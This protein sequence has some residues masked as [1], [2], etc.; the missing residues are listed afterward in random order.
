MKSKLTTENHA[1]K[2]RRKAE[3]KTA[4]QAAET[5]SVYCGLNDKKL[6]HELQVHKIELELQNEELRLANEKLSE[7]ETHLRNIIAKTP[8]GYFHLD[9]EGRF[10]DVNDAWLR[11]HGYDSKNEVIGKHFSIMQ[12]DSESESSLNHMDE[13]QRGLAIPSGEFASRRKDGSIGHHKFS[14]H[15]VVQYGSIVGFEWFIIDISERKRAEQ[16][17]LTNE[18]RMSS[19]IDI[20]RYL[21]TNEKEFLD[22]AL[23]EIITSTRSK[24]GYI[25][26]YSEQKRQF[27]LNTWSGEV[28]KECT[29]V[30]QQSKYDLDST[31]IWGEAVRQRRPILLNDFQAPEPLKKGVPDGH[32][33][34]KRFL[35]VPVISDGS[36]VAVVGVANKESDY[37]VAEATQLTLFMD[38]VWKIAAHKR[39]EI[40]QISLLSQLH[41]AQKMESVGRLAGGVAHDFN[42]MLSVIIGHAEIVLQRMDPDQTSY[43]S[44]IEIRKAAQRSADLTRQLLAFARKQTVIPRVVD[45]NEA[46]EG[47]LNMLQRLIGENIH[48]TWKR[49]AN[50]WPVMVDSSQVDQIMAN[51]CVNARD[52]IAD[53]GEIIIE[54]GNCSFDEHDCKSHNYTLPGDYVKI[55]VSDSGKGMDKETL[56]H[57]FEPFFTTKGVGE[58]TGLGLATIYGVVK[59]NNG[60]VNVYSEPGIGTTFT[61]YL[62]RYKGKSEQSQREVTAESSH[63]GHETILLVEDEPAILEMTSMLLT[64]LGYTVLKAS[65]PDGAIHLAQEHSAEINLLITDVIMP[66]M[67]GGELATRLLSIRPQIKLLFMSGYTADIIAHH[68]VLDE[69]VHFIQKPFLMNDF[70]DKLREVL[71]N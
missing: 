43:S 19:L 42:N 8:A 35:T 68:G 41:Q 5:E 62:P 18:N 24:I 23:E 40:E 44:I 46:V 36:I 55:V 56:D 13:L 27:T 21:F 57:I 54:T 17:Q 66:K 48:L 7:L 61:I 22:H 11:I 9:L 65:T 70:A 45:L 4:M 34:L 26:F 39:A 37:S 47:M 67:N 14:A 64:E 69:G 16:E 71:D 15:P 3:Q 1:A 33:A 50:L 25:Y 51:M 58:G 2:L 20:S 63:R 6:L 12:V 10:V 29:V 28:M 52:S 60:F 53:I 38:A 32:V 30:E 31:G 49:G 59:Q